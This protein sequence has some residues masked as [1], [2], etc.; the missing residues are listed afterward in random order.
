MND[1]F[2][3]LTKIANIL[4]LSIFLGIASA[5]YLSWKEKKIREAFY[6]ILVPFYVIRV[7]LKRKEDNT[8]KWL[9]ISVMGAFVILV[10]IQLVIIVFTPP[11]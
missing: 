2:P 3:L 7:I 10:F 1:S 6:V 4:W 11:V 5:A 8:K 9:S